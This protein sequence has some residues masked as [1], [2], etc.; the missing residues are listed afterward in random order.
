MTSI[1][2]HSYILAEI[3]ISGYHDLHAIFV[4]ASHQ[5]SPDDAAA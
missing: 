4:W 1:L 3:L 5:A 2:S